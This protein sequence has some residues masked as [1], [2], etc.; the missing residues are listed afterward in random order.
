MI[1]ILRYN[2]SILFIKNPFHYNIHTVHFKEYNALLSVA[3]SLTH[4]VVFNLSRP[5]TAANSN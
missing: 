5:V 2:C 1:K 4:C 3:D